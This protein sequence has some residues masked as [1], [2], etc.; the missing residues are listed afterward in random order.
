MAV[1]K[2][3]RLIYVALFRPFAG[4]KAVQGGSG[5]YTEGGEG[6]NSYFN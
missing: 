2:L 3:L 4:S 6:Q 1:M 5:R